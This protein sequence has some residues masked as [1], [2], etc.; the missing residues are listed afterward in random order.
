MAGMTIKRALIAGW[1]VAAA[2]FL[3]AIAW[4]AI[5]HHQVYENAPPGWIIDY[6]APLSLVILRMVGFLGLIIMAVVSISW[7]VLSKISKL[8]HYGRRKRQ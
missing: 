6:F 8:T 1:A 2:S 3:S 7:F 4:T 5:L